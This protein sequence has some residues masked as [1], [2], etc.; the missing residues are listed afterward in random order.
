MSELDDPN[1]MCLITMVEMSS[2]SLISKNGIVLRLKM[3]FIRQNRVSASSTMCD[4]GKKS[5]NYFRM[6]DMSFWKLH[7]KMKD[8]TNKEDAGTPASRRSRKNAGKR[9][10]Y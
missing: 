8:Q 10:S 6:R 9:A 4:L 2:L 5:K 3:Y 7:E 1:A